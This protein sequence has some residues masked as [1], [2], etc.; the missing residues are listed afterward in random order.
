MALN[1]PQTKR[2]QAAIGKRPLYYCSMTNPIGPLL[3]QATDEGLLRVDF[4]QPSALALQI[5]QDKNRLTLPFTQQLGT[6][7]EDHPLLTST[8]QALEGYFL[9]QST[10]FTQPIIATGTEFQTKV[11]Q[12]LRQIPYG[13][14][15]SYQQ[16]AQQIGKAKASRAVGMACG[17]NPI[18]IIVPC[19]RVI[20]SNGALTGYAGG[21]AYKR[22]L[23][24]LEQ[25]KRDE[26]V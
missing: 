21:L 14:T 24:K 18:G 12:A 11:W 22:A 19:H 9:G 7:A 5:K 8:K 15:I 6:L 10:A 2:Y 13:Q 26:E 17:K 20:G 4:Y 1:L 25:N 23:L 16:I 3:L